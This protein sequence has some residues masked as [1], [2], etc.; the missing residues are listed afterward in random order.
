MSIR[1]P[2]LHRRDFMKSASAFSVAAAGIKASVPK[3]T[4]DISP[5]I[6]RICTNFNMPAMA[7]LILH[8]TEVEAQGV[9]GVRERGRHAR[10]TLHDQWHLG[11]DTKAMT[12]TLCAMLVSQGKIDWNSTLGK[13]FPELKVTMNPAYRTVTILQLLTMRA[14]CPGE[15]AA[16]WV[17]NRVQ[18]Q[19]QHLINV[20]QEITRWILTRVPQ[21]APGSRFIYSNVGYVIAGHI[22]ERVTGVVWEK[23]MKTHIFLPLGMASAGFGAPGVHGKLDEPRGHDAAGRPVPLGPG[24][25]NPP[26]LGPAGTVHASIDDWAKFIALHLTM[27]RAHP[28]L[29]PASEFIRLHTPVMG[30]PPEPNYAMGWEVVKRSWG[31]G[32]VLTHSGSNTLWYCTAWLAPRRNFAIL[33]NCNQGGIQAAKACDA[34]SAAL[35]HNHLNHL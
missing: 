20:R 22:A 7:G 6:R 27:G 19:T 4:R 13:I 10:A 35:I 1:V 18:K 28:D 34:V 8:G 30:K 33:V 32:T 14:G 12:A 24:D 21:A 11:S 16:G 15:G 5:I 26:A 29:L 25:D 3:P 23:L 2:Y 31:G 9:T 17:W